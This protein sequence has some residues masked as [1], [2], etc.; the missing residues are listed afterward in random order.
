MKKFK[1]ST[2]K[3][4]MEVPHRVIDLGLWIC[5]KCHKGWLDAKFIKTCMTLIF[6]VTNQRNFVYIDRWIEWHRFSLHFWIQWVP[7]HN[8]KKFQLDRRKKHKLV[9]AHTSYNMLHLTLSKR[10]IKLQYSSNKHL[11]KHDIVPIPFLK[12]TI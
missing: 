11:E 7:K 3:E 4:V 12:S 2:S 9:Y 6:E 8:Q 1:F 5:L 10:A